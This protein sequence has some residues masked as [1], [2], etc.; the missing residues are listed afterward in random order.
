MF[1]RT[2]ECDLGD[3]HVDVDESEIEFMEADRAGA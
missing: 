1:A 3:L 2:K